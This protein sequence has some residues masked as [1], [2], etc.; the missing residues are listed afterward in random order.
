MAGSRLN[1]DYFTAYAEFYHDKRV[2]Y[3]HMQRDEQEHGQKCCNA[4]V[5]ARNSNVQAEQQQRLAQG[6]YKCN[7]DTEFYHENGKTTAG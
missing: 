1:T 3:A 7:V 6:W 5:V 4:N 2:H